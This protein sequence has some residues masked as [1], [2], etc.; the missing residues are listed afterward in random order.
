M[1]YEGVSKSDAYKKIVNKLRSGE[2]SA[3]ICWEISELCEKCQTSSPIMCVE[4]CQLWRF[5]RGCLD[6]NTQHRLEFIDVLTTTRNKIRQKILKT[7]IEKQCSKKELKDKLKTMG[8]N[9]SSSVLRQRYIKPL[10]DSF[11]IE[12]EDNLYKIT[13]IGTKMYNILTKSEIAKL[14]VGFSSSDEKILIA[15][16]S[17]PKSCNELAKTVP[18][19]SLT[20]RLKRLQVSGLVAVSTSSNHI[21]Y[22]RAKNRP[23]RKLSP[24]ELKIFKALPKE[25]I[26]IRDLSA[27]VDLSVRT[28]YNYLKSLRYKRHVKKEKKTVLYKLTNSGSS[29]VQSLNVARKLIF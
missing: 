5:K 25:G 15:L 21:F 6:V 26:S 2:N 28:I 23:T 9:Y 3:N 27:E 17:G 29:M 18:K 4:L 24:S 13:S 19:A 10:M 20:R 14:P 7:L 1:L 11:L 16:S 22:F 12:E 8:H